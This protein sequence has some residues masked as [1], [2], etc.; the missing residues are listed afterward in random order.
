MALHNVLHF[1]A[2]VTAPAPALP[3]RRRR[4]RPADVVH[5]RL[6]RVDRHPGRTSALFAIAAVL[7]WG[8]GIVLGLFAFRS[9]YEWTGDLLAGWLRWPIW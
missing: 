3:G 4:A 6:H 8:A 9:N 5:L 2:P 1:T 7:L